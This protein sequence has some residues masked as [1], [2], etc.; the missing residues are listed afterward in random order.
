MI[1]YEIHNTGDEPFTLSTGQELAPGEMHLG[2][3]LGVTIGEI[4]DVSLGHIMNKLVEIEQ[5]ISPDSSPIA[6]PQAES[7]PQ[8]EQPNDAA[9]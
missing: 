5:L 1:S 6:Q 8:A 9:A 2:G 3:S 4:P 7:E